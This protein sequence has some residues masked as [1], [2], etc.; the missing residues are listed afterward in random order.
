LTEALRGWNRNT[1]KGL[2]QSSYKPSL[3]AD[4]KQSGQRHLP[5]GISSHETIGSKLFSK[6]D[7]LKSALY[8]TYR[9]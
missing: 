4:L 8:F 2:I 6:G 7:P 9:D 3:T 1:E 5:G